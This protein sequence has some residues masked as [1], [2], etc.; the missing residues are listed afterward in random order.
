MA[1]ILKGKAMFKRLKNYSWNKSHINL[2]IHSACDKK[3]ERPPVCDLTNLTGVTGSRTPLFV[4]R[5]TRASNLVSYLSLSNRTQ[6]GIR[7]IYRR[8]SMYDK[9]P[10]NQKF[11]KSHKIYRRVCR[12]L[13]IVVMTSVIVRSCHAFTYIRQGKF[14]DTGSIEQVTIK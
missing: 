6:P 2:F 8:P 14:R 13:F 12:P 7:N 11:M 1:Q 9:Y 4:G 10:S 5:A 3:Q